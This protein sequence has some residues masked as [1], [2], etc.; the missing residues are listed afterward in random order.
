MDKAL[1]VVNKKAWTKPLSSIR[2]AT[3]AECVVISGANVDSG[4]FI[5]IKVCA[6]VI[7]EG[8]VYVHADDI[9]KV[10]NVP[11]SITAGSE[12]GAFRVKNNKKCCEVKAFDY[13]NEFPKSP[14][15]DFNAN[16][17]FRFKE[18]ELL[19][20]LE[21]LK[22]F[23][24]SDDYTLERKPLLGGYN[25]SGKKDRIVACDAHRLG[26]HQLNAT[27]YD[28]IDI[29]IQGGTYKILKKLADAKDEKDVDV[30]VGSKSKNVCFKG[31]DYVYI[32]RL[33]TGEYLNVEPVMSREPD[34]EFTV[35]SKELGNIAK[36]YAKVA[37]GT[38]V[39]MC[40]I[41]HNNGLSA[42][43]SLADYQTADKIET[44]TGIEN[45]SDDFV[46]CLDPKFVNETVCVFDG[47][48]IKMRAGANLMLG[49]RFENKDFNCMVLPC[50]GS[51]ELINRIRKLVEK[52][53]I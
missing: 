52:I 22:S 50:T 20:A 24:A 21:K 25:I 53:E 29:T 7:E 2:I 42:A 3:D 41:K 12:G 34:F 10:Y 16:P 46:M 36:E 6:K 18:P 43:I 47:G 11:G 28:R 44:A 45:I 30:Y 32:S 8:C 17:S 48:D 49:M 15:F 9:V 35:S 14:K 37:K 38:W 40:F 13:E 26:I 33:L 19:F 51:S 27:V 5:S 1:S 4:E 31:D 23:L 39:P